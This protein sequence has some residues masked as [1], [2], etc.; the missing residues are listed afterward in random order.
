MTIFL[1]ILA[2]A[3]IAAGIVYY[4][5]TE[6]QA[7]RCKRQV[8]SATNFLLESNAYYVMA[9]V[10]LLTFE[11]LIQIDFIIVSRFGVFIVASYDYTG[12]IEAYESSNSWFQIVNSKEKHE[13]NNPSFQLNKNTE[14]VQ[15]L[16]DI[17]KNKIFSVLVFDSITG[18]TSTMRARTTYGKDYLNYIRSK[19]ELLLTT[20]EI[21]NII[22]TIEA[23]RKKQGLVS[24]LK[25][26]D[27]SNQQGTILD[28]NRSCPSCGSDMVIKVEKNGRNAG[29]QYLQCVLYPTCRS[30]RTSK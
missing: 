6:I 30:T 8:E 1:I 28:D 19:Q 16:I 12:V 14:T 21:K 22:E 4:R 2:S 27:T 29:E 20:D 3:F 24:G 13:F 11:G 10:V 7:W 18:F 15:S 25:S 17:D 23:K 9:D 5:W 26:I